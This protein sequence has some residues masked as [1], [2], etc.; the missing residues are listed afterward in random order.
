MMEETSALA[1]NLAAIHRK[2]RT[3]EPGSKL[4]FVNMANVAMM[5]SGLRRQPPYEEVLDYV[6]TDP[7]KV[8]YPNRTAKLLRSTLPINQF[9]GMGQALLEQQQPEQTK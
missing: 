5:S 3:E 4:T 8:K 9:Y 2:C 7:E 6:E 1:S